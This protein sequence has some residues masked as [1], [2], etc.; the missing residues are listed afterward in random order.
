MCFWRNAFE[1]SERVDEEE[2]ESEEER[3]EKK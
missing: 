1:M 2:E 3:Q